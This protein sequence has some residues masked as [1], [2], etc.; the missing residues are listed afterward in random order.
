MGNK[1]FVRRDFV[2]TLAA[3]TQMSPE[4]LQNITVQS[5]R[6]AMRMAMTKIRHPAAKSLVQP[7]DHYRQRHPTPL[8]AGLFADFVTQTLLR[9]PRRFHAQVTAGNDGRDQTSRVRTGT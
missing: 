7:S 8:R 9:L 1:P 2:T 5:M 6:N 3:T 4:P